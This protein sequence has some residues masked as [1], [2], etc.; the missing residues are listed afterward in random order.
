MKATSFPNFNLYSWKICP[1]VIDDFFYRKKYKKLTVNSE[2]PPRS[3][4]AWN[5]QRKKKKKRTNK[6]NT[7]MQKQA[8]II[9]NYLYCR[10]V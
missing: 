7:K 8:Q 10:Y 9:I 3:Q 1:I 2:N 5:F 6:R 4:N